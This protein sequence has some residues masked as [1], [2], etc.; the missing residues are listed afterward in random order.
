MKIIENIG[1][2]TT[3][4]IIDVEIIAA[5]VIGGGALLNGGKPVPNYCAK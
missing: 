5:A 1:S 3:E 2:Y 4:S